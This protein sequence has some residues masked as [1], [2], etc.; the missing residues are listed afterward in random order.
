M[1]E[2]ADRSGNIFG[3]N[4]IMVSGLPNL[5]GMGLMTGFGPPFRVVCSTVVIKE[6]LPWFRK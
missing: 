5:D 4:L 6:E 2:L 1:A 3:S